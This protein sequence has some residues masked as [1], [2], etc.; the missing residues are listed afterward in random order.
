MDRIDHDRFGRQYPRRGW[1]RRGQPDLGGR[2]RFGVRTARRRRHVQP[3]RDGWQSDR[4]GGFGSRI[5]P[6]RQLAGFARCRGAERC[7]TGLERSVWQHSRPDGCRRLD[8]EVAHFPHKMMI[9]SARHVTARRD[10]R[11]RARHR[12][13]IETSN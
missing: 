13:S 7:S 6:G 9:V 5:D 8:H 10:R 11:R 1:R 3:G 4:N 12:R 2:G